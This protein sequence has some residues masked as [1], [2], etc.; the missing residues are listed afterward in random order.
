MPWYK[1]K[2]KKSKRNSK[3]NYKLVFSVCGVTF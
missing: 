1:T 2:R 3:R